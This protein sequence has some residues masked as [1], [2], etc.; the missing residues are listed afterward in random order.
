MPLPRTPLLT[1]RLLLRPYEP[2]D[3]PAFFAL[4]H[5]NRARLHTSFPDRVRAVAAPAGAPAAL[6]A[7]ADDWHSGR[8]YVLGIWLRATGAYLGDICLMPQTGGQAEIGYYL[9]HEAEGQG[10]AR[11]ALAAVCRFGFDA[12]GAQ[13]LLVRCFADNARGQAVA[14]AAGFR[15]ETPPPRFAWFRNA[16]AV[17]SIRRFVQEKSMGE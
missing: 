13:R 5:Q 4:L 3:A 14:L 15:P 16:D 10:Y 8:F 11:E 1:P 17:G 7:F 6:A 12:V 9:A 2:A